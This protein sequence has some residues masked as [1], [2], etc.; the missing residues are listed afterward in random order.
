MASPCPDSLNNV[1]STLEVKE[2]LSTVHK[3]RTSIDDG[4]QHTRGVNAAGGRID[5]IWRNPGQEKVV[6]PCL[7][8]PGGKTL[9]RTQD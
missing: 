2:D 6:L 8:H 3:R 1:S 5:G 4:Q 7:V 9:G